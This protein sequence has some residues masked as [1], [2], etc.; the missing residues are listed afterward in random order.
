MS[1]TVKCGQCGTEFQSRKWEVENGLGKF[2]SRSCSVTYQNKAYPREW[3][4]VCAQCGSG[5]LAKSSNDHWCGVT[6]QIKHFTP[7]TVHGGCMEWTGVINKA[8]YGVYSRGDVQF[9]AHRTAWEIA[10]NSKAP[11]GLFII[12]RCDN[13]K[14][15]NPKH[16]RVGTHQDNMDDMTSRGRQFKGPRVRAVERRGK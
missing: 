10:N 3:H 1:I 2:C 4:R 8:G 11:K 9:R 14:C 7:T 16:L 5:F 13:R 15:V 12:H 6:C